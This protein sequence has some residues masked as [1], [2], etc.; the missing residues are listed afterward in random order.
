MNKSDSLQFIYK[1]EIQQGKRRVFYF[2]PKDRLK[3]E[4]KQKQNLSRTQKQKDPYSPTLI[5]LFSNSSIYSLTLRLPS[6]ALHKA[7]LCVFVEGT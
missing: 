4:N 5:L 6:F 7:L 2:A 3:D 1:T